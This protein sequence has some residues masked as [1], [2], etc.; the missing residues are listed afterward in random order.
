MGNDRPA[1]QIRMTFVLRFHLE[2]GETRS[3]WRGSIQ[4]AGKSGAGCAV[5]SGWPILAFLRRRLREVA[6]VP[7]PLFGVPGR[8]R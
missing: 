3:Y 6:G 8:K 1:G 2:P 5:E 7:L 4:E